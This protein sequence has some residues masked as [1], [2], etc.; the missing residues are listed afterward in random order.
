MAD[1]GEGRSPVLQRM[2]TGVPGLDRLLG[3]G[4]VRGSSYILQG[5]PGAG[6]T[7]LANQVCH[8]RARRGERA[9]YLTLLSE[10][11]AQM[12]AFLEPL[13]F[14]D[15]AHVPDQVFY[16][17]A[18]ATLR[19][20]GLSALTRMIQRE[21]RARKPGVV[22]LDGLYAAGERGGESEHA[23][24]RF[25]NELST[26]AAASGFTLLLLTNANRKPSSPEYTMVDGW[27]ELEDE[28]INER[29]RRRVVV[30]KHRGGPVLR[31][32]HDYV[33][34]DSGLTMFPRLETI[35]SREPFAGAP[36]GRLSS[37]VA[38]LD[39][40]MH[41]GIPERSSTVVLGPTG[42]GKTTI[43]LQFLSGS[44]PDEPGLLFGFYETPDRLVRKAREI[45]IDLPDLV[46]RGAVR[47]E[48][49]P[50]FENHID[51]L[52]QRVVDAAAAIGAKRVVVD[53]I[54]ALRRPVTNSVRLHAFLR[55]FNDMLK[56]GG[57]TSLF[58]REVPQLFFPEA[59]AVDELSG[60]ID[61]TLFLHYALDGNVVRRRAT[62]IKV[63]D[64]DFDHLSREFEITGGGLAFSRSDGGARLDG[65]TTS[66]T[67]VQSGG[68]L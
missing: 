22:V 47:I 46:D 5:A 64:S 66:A 8:E 44:T 1:S 35:A 25:I 18:Y 63:R 65:T 68:A 29:A 28:V 2:E 58:T 26:L 45:G 23:F 21:V 56:V 60:L 11:F 32:R 40:M 20:D 50:P 7:I 4:F 30:H 38:A 55:A 36:T 61:N 9:L 48:W 17:S 12:F 31:G 51:E 37:G 59:L 24:R 33:I 57:A 27:I 3:G 34:R 42:S 62:L 14:F 16:A 43:G 19:D 6:K 53:G 49:L 39:A 13:E 52:G 15:L 67:V 54:N 10:S 41:G